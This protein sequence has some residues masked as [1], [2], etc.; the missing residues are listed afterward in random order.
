MLLYMDIISGDE[1]FSDAFT[2]VL[3]DDVLYEVDCKMITIGNDNVDIGAN[4]SAEDAPDEIMDDAKTVNNLVHTSR[5]EPT[6]FNKKA[7]ISY[8]KGYMK[9]IKSKMETNGV[10]PEDIE[11]FEKK[12][13]PKVKEILKKYDDYEFYTGESRNPEAMVALLN[14]REDGIT[15][16]FTFFKHGLKEQKF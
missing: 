1:L 2:P 3:I 7:Y 6:I 5:L 13:T 10:E 9:E 14:Y 11:D 8:I 16:Y 15:P 12:I 4:P